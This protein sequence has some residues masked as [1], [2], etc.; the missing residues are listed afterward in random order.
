MSPSTRPFLLPNTFKRPCLQCG[1]PHTRATNTDL[2]VA[3]D[4]CPGRT[5][6]Y[7]HWQASGAYFVYIGQWRRP[8]AVHNRQHKVQT[9]FTRHARLPAISKKP[10]S[11]LLTQSA[12]KIVSIERRH[13]EHRKTVPRDCMGR[14]HTR[15][16]YMTRTLS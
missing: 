5:R 4:A 6:P 15:Y 2:W 9:R 14:L 13:R 8:N 11:C 10:I 7:T 1:K 16:I 12:R 3:I